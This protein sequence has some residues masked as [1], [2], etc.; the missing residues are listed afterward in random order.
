MKRITKKIV[1]SLAALNIIFAGAVP[2]PVTNSNMSLSRSVIISADAATINSRYMN[3]KTLSDK[4]LRVA[5][6]F[7]VSFANA[8]AYG[9]GIKIS[10]S[11]LK[12]IAKNSKGWSYESGAKR[13]VFTKYLKNESNLQLKYGYTIKGDKSSTVEDK[14]L[15]SFLSAKR[16]NVAIAHVDF[17]YITLLDYNAKNNTFLVCDGYTCNTRKLPAYGW[18]KASK[19][20]SGKAAVDWFCMIETKVPLKGVLK[21]ILEILNL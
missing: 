2:L 9:N 8:I 16:G 12:K 15:K 21:S 20:K 13:K 14:A 11:E 19:L 10:E 7:P 17:H 3:Q 18:V 1:T 6:C 5:G 4:Q